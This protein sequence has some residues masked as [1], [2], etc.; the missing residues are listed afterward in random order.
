MRRGS[1]RLW[2]CPELGHSITW[3][4]EYLLLAL[5]RFWGVLV[6]G[7]ELKKGAAA[8]GTPAG[9]TVPSRSVD[10]GYIC[11]IQIP[12]THVRIY[13]GSGVT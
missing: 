7:V 9:K 3:N 11:H 4:S 2:A 10:I 13:V 5:F 6:K 8:Q 12:W 1:P